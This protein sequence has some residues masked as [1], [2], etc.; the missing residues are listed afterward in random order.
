[1]DLRF[2]MH[3]HSYAG[4]PHI[5]NRAAFLNLYHGTLQRCFSNTA[6]LRSLHGT[7]TP[8]NFVCGAKTVER[9][10]VDSFRADPHAKRVDVSAM[11]PRR[12]GTQ[13]EVGGITR[14]IIQKHVFCPKKEPPGRVSREIGAISP[15]KRDQHPDRASLVFQKQVQPSEEARKFNYNQDEITCPPSPMSGELYDRLRLSDPLKI[16][17]LYNTPIQFDVIRDIL[18]LPPTA[19]PE[20]T[21]LWNTIVVNDTPVEVAMADPRALSK[22]QSFYIFLHAKGSPRVTGFYENTVGLLWCNSRFEDAF[23]AHSMLYPVHKPDSWLKLVQL[24]LINR[25]TESIPALLRIHATLDVSADGFSAPHTRFLEFLYDNVSDSELLCSWQTHLIASGDLPLDSNKNF[26]LN[27]VVNSMRRNRD[28]IGFN[29]LLRGI[30]THTALAWM[31]PK[32]V[33]NI[34]L[35]AS[36]LATSQPKHFKAVLRLFQTHPYLLSHDCWS[37]VYFHSPK[38][39]LSVID[40]IAEKHIDITANPNALLQRCLRSVGKA[41]FSKNTSLY[42][43]QGF[44]KTATYYKLAILDMCATGHLDTALAMT[45]DICGLPSQYCE[46][47]RK[48]D[49]KFNKKVT[50]EVLA[51]MIEGATKAKSTHHV[52]SIE[53]YVDNHPDLILEKTVLLLATAFLEFS[54][55]D[56]VFARLEVLLETGVSGVSP[57]E[58]T[59]VIEHILNDH[60][61][62]KVDVLELVLICLCIHKTSSRIEPYLWQKLLRLVG[63]QS[64]MDMTYKISSWL[65]AELRTENLHTSESHA[66]RPVQR[67]LG[68]DFQRRFVIWG[69][70]CFPSEPW[71][72]IE[73]LAKLRAQGLVLDVDA[74]RGQVIRVLRHIWLSEYL[75]LK[76]FEKACRDKLREP[77]KVMERYNAAWNK[78]VS[79]EEE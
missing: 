11:L 44:P 4:K 14:D 42:L 75:T 55:Y 50:N 48:S 58:V 35:T 3:V 5:T 40:G 16:V 71:K 22:L 54:C 46:N 39:P 36:M 6:I 38:V 21:R 65:V 60:Q 77:E 31:V 66:R 25:N 67:V 69:V 27:K 56:K 1:M 7:I 41:A 59:K 9:P 29:A 8:E 72:A 19:S 20:V 30:K 18:N 2:R 51:G 10:S 63:Y 57:I 17:S 62:C 12:K 68:V 76:P 34:I 43:Q 47:N 28:R 78:Q 53:E 32:T 52:T 49:R 79:N 64:D 74:I 73:Y 37:F 23:T 15:V 70:R 61:N 24:A 45:R 26:V 13:R 33:Q